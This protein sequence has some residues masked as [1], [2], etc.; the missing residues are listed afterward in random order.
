LDTQER[1]TIDQSELEMGFR[2]AVTRQA[3][4]VA[5]SC[6][7]LNGYLQRAAARNRKRGKKKLIMELGEAKSC[8]PKGD[9]RL[10]IA[11]YDGTRDFAQD[12]MAIMHK[13]NVTAPPG[14][15]WPDD[16]FMLVVHRDVYS[17]MHEEVVLS[18]L[19]DRIGELSTLFKETIEDGTPNI[20]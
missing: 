15:V 18:G 2:A 16:V 8:L 4:P 20:N 19:F 5:K 11:Q 3:D 6:T 7:V 14:A 17:R 9:I 1:D 12:R 10:Y 13:G